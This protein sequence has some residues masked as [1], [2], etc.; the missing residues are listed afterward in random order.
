MG[1]V[2][3]ISA[4][5]L[6]LVVTPR[7]FGQSLGNT[8]SVA[9]TV[10]D[11]SGAV[12]PNAT[13]T[14]HNMVSG[15]TQ[16]VKSD[17]EGAFRLVNVP[18]NPY[19][20]DVTAEGFDPFAQDLSVKPGLP[21]QIKV[22]LMVAGTQTRVNVEA[23]GDVLETDPSSHVDVD[24]SLIVKLP[25]VDPAAGLSAAITYSTGGVAADANGFFHPL[26]DHSQVSFVID[27]Q[28]ISD[29][30]S[31]LFSTQLP[32]DAIQS[33]EETTGSPEAQFGDKSSLV[34]QITTRSGLGAGRLFGNVDATYGSFGEAGGSAALG[35][36]TAKVGNFVVANGIRDGRFLDTPEFAAIHDIGNNESIFDRFDYQPGGH[37]AFH[38]NLFTAR[39]WFQI[40]N[41]YD[42]LLQDQHQ[43]ALT[44]NAAPGYQHTFSESTLL[45]INPY[46]RKDQVNYLPQ[47]RSLRRYARHAEPKPAI[48]ELGRESGC[49]DDEGTSH[50]E[51]GSGPEA[52]A[53]ARKLRLRHYRSDIQLALHQ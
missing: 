43:R 47:P 3:A 48:A 18:A 17:S 4:L 50:V 39:N 36:G 40:P 13:V 33:M 10:L 5:G 31:K 8:G 12:V 11:P 38:L 53:P 45:T 16:T 30:Q 2:L 21:V 20:L 22:N 44:W 41:D 37:D 34:A 25:T 19:H 27:G 6:F 14:I 29:Q 51:S 7:V 46:I 52:D 9:G 28:P 26:G 15:Y 32:T 1:K 42:Q 24:R 23:A 49:L 35:Y